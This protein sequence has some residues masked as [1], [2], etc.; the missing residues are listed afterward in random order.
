MSKLTA[1]LYHGTESLKDKLSLNVDINAHQKTN[2]IVVHIQTT[3]AM[4]QRHS[5]ETH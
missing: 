3:A 4:L 2:Y 1:M 5:V